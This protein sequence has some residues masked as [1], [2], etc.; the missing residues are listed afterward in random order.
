MGLLDELKKRAAAKE[1]LQ[2][3]NTESDMRADEVRAVALPALFRIHANLAE[4]VKQLL[5]LQEETPVSLKIAGIGDV[6]GFQQGNYS[7]SAEGT[8]P[9]AVTL[10][11]ALRPGKVRPLE[12]TTAGASPTTW[13]DR[14]RRQDLPLKIV[15]VTDTR[16]PNQKALVTIE[17]SEIGRASCRERVC[18]AV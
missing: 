11:C 13:I 1:P 4:L 5:I 12:L 3:S 16:G 18:L 7:V 6:S 9:H 10:R 8:P 17:G 2:T 14:L 15:R